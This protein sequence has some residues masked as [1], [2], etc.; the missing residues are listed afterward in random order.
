MIFLS[1][2]AAHRAETRLFRSVPKFVPFVLLALC[3]SAGAVCDMYSC[4]DTS[5]STC[6]A[7]AAGKAR[8]ACA[9]ACCMRSSTVASNTM[10]LVVSRAVL[11]SDLYLSLFCSSCCKPAFRLWAFSSANNIMSRLFMCC[12]KRVR[13]ELSGSFHNPCAPHHCLLSTGTYSYE[14]YATY[15]TSGAV[16]CPCPPCPCGYYCS[17]GTVESACP[18]GYYCPAGS[19][20]LTSCANNGCVTTHPRFQSLR[21]MRCQG[22]ISNCTSISQFTD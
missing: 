8:C 18:S 9:L 11:S 13:V 21:S 22:W 12:S 19:S 14:S 20:T 3:T 16:V 5:T 15:Q 2:A 7:C 4:M 17:G 1:Q 10:V 6:V